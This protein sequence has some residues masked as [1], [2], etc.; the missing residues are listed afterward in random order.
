M[1]KS[2]LLLALWICCPAAHPISAQ[3]HRSTNLVAKLA[4]AQVPAV[5]QALIVNGQQVCGP[6]GSATS[7][8]VEELN[9][10]KNRT[11]IPSTYVAIDWKS[12]AN[13]PAGNVTEIED[14][15]GLNRGEDPLRRSKAHDDSRRDAGIVLLGIKQTRMYI[16]ALDAPGHQANQAIIEPT[17]DGCG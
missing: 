7:P 11:D 1:K 2:I 8:R 13:L 6:A 9:N 10:N 4:A 3:T 5:G 16:I 15:S 12:A 14:S 17:P